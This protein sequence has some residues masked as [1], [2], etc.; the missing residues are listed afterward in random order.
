MNN[1]KKIG[2][3]ALAGSL[4]AITTA[5][6]VEMGVSGSAKVTYKNGHTTEVNG[7][8]FGMNTSLG[9]SGTG[10]VNGY[11]TTLFV[12]TMDQFGG[13]TSGSLAVDLG[14]MGKIT[15]DQ[16]TGAGGISTIDDKTP[17]A[18]EEVWDGLD[19]VTGDSNGLVGG[20]NGGAFVYANSY[21]DTAFTGQLTK[22]ASNNASDDATSGEGSTG[23]SWDFA[24][25]NASLA[26]GMNAGVGYGQISTAM[27]SGQNADNESEHMTAFV[28][29]S[30]GM[31]TAGA[32]MSWVEDA[33]AGG[34]SEE[35]TGW[36]LA[37]NLMDGLSVSY[38][39]REIEHQKH[40][41]TTEDQEG[42]AVAYTMGAA[43]ITFQNN[44]TSAN[45]GTAGTNDEATEIA[46][47]LSF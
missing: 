9:F 19:A 27:T 43:K 29:Y 40:N 37:V 10:D 7:N 47:S 26:E 13:M 25:T 33:S 35:A 30:V 38:G 17:S 39:E 36:G 16:G 34:D 21:G 22:G 44:E 28:T 3:S 1:F 4:A 41:L 5:G 6:A 20:G 24:L 11:A 45:G 31:V 8:P 46:L 2:L 18:N 23:T 15:F 14:D 32:Q 12:Q 42:I